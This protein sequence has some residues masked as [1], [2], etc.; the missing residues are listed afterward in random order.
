VPRNRDLLGTIKGVWVIRV[1]AAAF[2]EPS[3]SL[4]LALNMEQGVRRSRDRKTTRRLAPV[5]A[6]PGARRSPLAQRH[7]LRH[8]QMARTEPTETG[9]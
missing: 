2:L 9:V 3:D 5:G 7:G 6:C 8:S 1:H 4:L